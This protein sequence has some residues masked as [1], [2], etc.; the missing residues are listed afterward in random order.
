MIR[1]IFYLP[2]KPLQTD[3]APDA[4]LKAFHN[5]RG[6]LWVDFVAE[7]PEACE[8]ILQSFEFHPLA[9]EDALQQ[10]HGPKIDD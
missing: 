5:R 9:I 7:P 8:P 4:L 3:L 1:S 6:L 2:G 10:T